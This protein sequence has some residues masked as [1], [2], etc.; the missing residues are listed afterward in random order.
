MSEAIQFIDLFVDQGF[1]TTVVDGQGNEKLGRDKKPVRAFA[2]AQGSVSAVPLVILMGPRTKST[3][4]IVA[5][6]FKEINRAVLIGKTSFGKFSASRKSYMPNPYNQVLTL[7]T[8][9]FF[10]MPS[11]NIYHG[12][13]V[14]PHIHIGPSPLALPSALE[15]KYIYLAK[16]K[17]KT[18]SAQRHTLGKQKNLSPKIMATMLDQ[19]P[20]PYTY[21][22]DTQKQ[23]STLISQAFS[24]KAMFGSNWAFRTWAKAADAAGQDPLVQ[25][26]S[27]VIAQINDKQCTPAYQLLVHVA[28][29]SLILFCLKR[30]SI[31]TES[32]CHCYKNTI[33]KK[34]LVFA[35]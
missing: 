8:E 10:R 35:T 9:G 14:D 17:T 26:A 7:I 4:E 15:K 18:E 5:A 23:Y 27:K 11:G 25:Y 20:Y 6:Y 24:R 2:R 12:I 32:A 13:G 22:P 1:I 19:N 30:R 34:T 28:S 21:N 16:Q 31:M 3:A 29:A 33:T